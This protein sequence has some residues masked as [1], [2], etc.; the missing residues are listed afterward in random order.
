MSAEPKY[1]ERQR[2]SLVDQLRGQC[3]HFTGIS[4]TS[5][6]AGVR[7]IDVRRRGDEGNGISLPCLKK[8]N[9]LGA[10]C[11][12]S[13]FPTQE[14][15]EQRKREHDEAFAHAMEARKR[16][17]ATGALHGTVECPRCNG[18]LHFSKASSNGHIHARCE[19]ADCLAWME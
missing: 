14:E 5:C 1:T 12:H 13:D 11:A 10:T 7:Y 18:P 8:Y 6:K 4:N 9:E 17:V 19:T 3:K 15:A 16:C 2:P